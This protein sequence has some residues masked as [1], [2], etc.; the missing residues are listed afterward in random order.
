MP[1]CIY[2]QP[3]HVFVVVYDEEMRIE[4]IWEELLLKFGLKDIEDMVHIP[5]HF[6]LVWRVYMELVW[7]YCWF[8]V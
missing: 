7:E 6:V 5:E 2:R 3:E 8:D 1:G 4:L